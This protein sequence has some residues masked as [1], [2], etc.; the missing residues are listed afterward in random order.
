MVPSAAVLDRFWRKVEKLGPERCWLWTGGANAKGYGRFRTEGRVL[1]S[2]HRLAYEIA[3][4]PIP[5]G[6]FV[7]HRC[8]NP[9]CVNPA[10]L[11]AGSH[12]ENMKDAHM[13]S[14]LPQALTRERRIAQIRA[15]R[16]GSFHPPEL[17]SRVQNYRESTGASYSEIGVT[18]GI[19]DSTARLWCLR[20]SRADW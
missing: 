10:H 9:R 12:S 3:C 8:D 11:F 16:G 13:K 19:S 20:L 4:G 5:E 6:M 7:C 1:V 2:P 17:V 15:G 18:F 14:R